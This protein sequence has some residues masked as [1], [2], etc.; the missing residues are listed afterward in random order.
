[1]EITKKKAVGIKLENFCRLMK[2]C[3]CFAVNQKGRK[4]ETREERKKKKSS[5]FLREFVFVHEKLS[6]FIDFSHT[7]S[8]LLLIVVACCWFGRSVVVGVVVLLLGLNQMIVC[9][10]QNTV[11]SSAGLTRAMFAVGLLGEFCWER[12]VFSL[13]LSLFGEW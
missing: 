3:F 10:K 5:D 2:S 7:F 1:M 13:S 12:T 6:I 8:I 4:N 11:S 9:G